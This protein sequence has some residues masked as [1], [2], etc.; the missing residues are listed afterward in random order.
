MH[1]LDI[2]PKDN[3][4]PVFKTKMIWGGETGVETSPS[5]DKIIPEKGY[6]KG[7]V[8]W[9]SR[10]A[11]RIKSDASLKELEQLYKFYVKD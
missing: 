6:V 2:F 5:L 7:N 1:L 11:N 4:C 10:R 3:I 8:V 9:V